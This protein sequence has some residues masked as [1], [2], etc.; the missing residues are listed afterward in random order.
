FETGLMWIT[1]TILAVD[2]S[3][4][5]FA[6]DYAARALHRRRPVPRPDSVPGMTSSGPMCPAGPRAMVSP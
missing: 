2:I 1:V 5:Q 3:L 4:I 6:G